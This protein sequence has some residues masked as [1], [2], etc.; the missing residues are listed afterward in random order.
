MKDLVSIFGERWGCDVAAITAP[1]HSHF[2]IQ[3]IENGNCDHSFDG[4]VDSL[5][6]RFNGRWGNYVVQLVNLFFLA[7]T[8]GVKKVFICSTDVFCF[9]APLEIAGITIDYVE[10]AERDTGFQ[11]QGV[12]FS[13]LPF[14]LLGRNLDA[15]RRRELALRY[16]HPLMAGLTPSSSIRPSDLV[17]HIRS[18]DIFQGEDGQGGSQ[19]GGSLYVQPPLAFYL[20][21][22]ASVFLTR[23]GH[24]VIV[25]ENSL[26]PVI[27]PL[28]D[29]LHQNGHA[30]SL[31]LNHDLKSDLEILLAARSAVYANGTIGVAVAL[32]SYE[33]ADGY[34]FRTDSTG[35]PHDVDYFL[36]GWLRKHFVEDQAGSYIP[37]GC[38][39]ND[40]GQR[41]LMTT[42]AQSSLSWLVEPDL[43]NV[44]LGKPA[45]Q[46]SVS[47]FSVA[48][49]SDAAVDGYVRQGFAFH[50]DRQHFPWWQVD[51]LSL[52][53]IEQI[54]V[55]NRDACSERAYFMQV[56]V[57][58]DQSWRLVHEQEGLPFGG[59]GGRPARI[60]LGGAKASAVRIQ[61]PAFQYLHLSQV[62][63][64]GRTVR[65]GET[66]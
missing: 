66:Y 47:S 6:V 57:L 60:M 14:G 53:E 34:F 46:S 56:Y 63:V 10:R 5:R 25:A 64:Y 40:A 48:N 21:A 38:W 49:E 58:Q 3:I 9:S 23:P 7:E 51:L 28:A 37:I 65:S 44:A 15:A 2:S 4:A 62:E 1:D 61:L 12:F 13:I 32:L 19:S 55:H 33:I 11:M 54:V 35:T 36:N 18:G 42:L 26:N 52:F 24:V 22:V 17:I 59:A 29:A 45:R 8:L 31:R 30:V 39:R 41:S 43:R 16:V 50:T 27:Y 20:M